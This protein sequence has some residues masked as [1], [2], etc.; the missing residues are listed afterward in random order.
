MLTHLLWFDISLI[1]L[2]SIDD[3]IISEAFNKK[4]RYRPKKIMV[5]KRNTLSVFKWKIDSLVENQT[6]HTET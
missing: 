2:I 4:S 1:K 6:L 3:Q 5:E